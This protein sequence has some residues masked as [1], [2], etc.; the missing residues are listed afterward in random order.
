MTDYGAV[1][2][3]EPDAINRL[4]ITL[5]LTLGSKRF[6]V[7]G[8]N[9]K[10]LT[11]ALRPFGFSGSLDF[12]F[13][14]IKDASEDGI[15]SEFV[16]Q[17][18]ATC[19]LTLDRGF[20]T[21]GESA[22]PTVLRGVVVERAVSERAFG[23]ITGEPVL[24]RHYHIAFGDRA[25]VMWRQHYPT[26]LYV[27][28][29]LAQLVDDNKPDGVKLTHAWQP[30]QVKYPVLSLALGAEDDGASFYDYLH[31]LLDQ[32]QC[33]LFYDY[34]TDCYTLSDKKKEFGSAVEVIPD[35]VRS[36]VNRYPPVMRAAVSVLNG[37]TL[38]STT[39]QTVE[40]E[41]KVSGVRR[42][43]LLRSSVASD[44]S[45]RAKLETKRHA[46]WQ[47]QAEVDFARYPSTTMRPNLL[48]KFGQWSK[49]VYQFGK[50]YRV[51]EVDVQASAQAQG[52][53]DQL[54]DP[55]NAYRV[56]YRAR[57]ERKE[58][59]RFAYPPFRRPSWDLHVEGKV[60][61]EVGEETQETYQSYK[62]DNTAIDYYK[63][64]V[65][66]WKKRKVVVAY[67]PLFAPGH[68]Y[69]PLYKGQRVLVALG[70]ARATVV[71]FV[72]WRPGARLPLET[73]GNHL[74]LGKQSEDQTSISHVYKDARPQLNIERSH[75]KDRQTLEVSEG[76]IFLRT[77][78][79]DGN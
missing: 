36:W 45:D 20:D 70:Y 52:P 59:T 17:D 65:P 71:G 79:T 12:W 11:L 51:R 18:L 28:K 67:E 9:I 72:D 49:N 13:V 35:D 7:P 21:V 22:D 76:R 8:G 56:E 31:W 25:Q 14:C 6:T 44:L 2:Q 41:Q 43:Y 64:E 73:Q 10:N 47:P 78:S 53:T 5:D 61:S 29:T 63:V 54:E 34:V 57:L 23:D 48:L 42:D 40:N 26:A 32:H 33:G 39:A 4:L 58:E 62:D 16:K 38:A 30:G 66:L 1:A 24:Q 60:V 46:Q 19:K 69:F 27:D 75:G 50:Q 68:F 3:A 74:L 15:L 77:L 37:C 55:S